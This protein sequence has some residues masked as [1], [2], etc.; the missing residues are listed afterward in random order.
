MSVFREEKV[1]T[2][3]MENRRKVPGGCK[4]GPEREKPRVRLMF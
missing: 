4:F 3:A 2:G 1:D